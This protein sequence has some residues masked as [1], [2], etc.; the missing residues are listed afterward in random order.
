MEWKIAETGSFCNKH[1]D[2]TEY[3]ACIRILPHLKKAAYQN[4]SPSTTSH[5][6]P[7]KCRWLT[8]HSKSY[9]PCDHH[10]R[11]DSKN[12]LFTKCRNRRLM[13]P[14][15]PESTGKLCSAT[16]GIPKEAENM[17]S[18]GTNFNP[19]DG[20]LDPQ[21]QICSQLTKLKYSR[22]TCRPQRTN[23]SK[24]ADELSYCQI[25]YQLEGK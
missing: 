12:V 25:V 9:K 6:H 2:S 11:T 8:T 22:L 24:A 18:T 23:Q 14:L 13:I 16:C 7:H 17:W 20:R 21:H 3:S 5:C 15:Y 1:L 19:R 10:K 4:L